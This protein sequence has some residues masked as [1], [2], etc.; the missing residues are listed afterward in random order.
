MSSADLF[1]VIYVTGI[2]S[3]E[4]CEK[5]L[6]ISDP[7]L[8]KFDR[9]VDSYDQAKKQMTDMRRPAN[10]SASQAVFCGKQRSDNKPQRPSNNPNRQRPDLPREEIE[11]RKTLVNR[12]YRCGKNDHL[13]PDCSRPAHHSCS[14]CGR[15]GHVRPACSK[16]ASANNTTSRQEDEEQQ[17][18]NKFSTMTIN[19]QM[20]Q[21]PGTAQAVHSLYLSLIHI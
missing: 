17:L 19:N 13:M 9:M 10:T 20:E 4:L 5:L 2:R 7:T 3:N 12:C 11:R 15:K 14:I 1:C 21:H 8:E 6:E 18:V 16:T